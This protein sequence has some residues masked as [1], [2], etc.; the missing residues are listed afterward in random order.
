MGKVFS[1]VK[2]GLSMMVCGWMGCSMVREFKFISIKAD[3]KDRSNWVKDVE[4]VFLKIKTVKNGKDNGI[5]IS[6]R[7]KVNEN[8]FL[9]F[10]ILNL[11]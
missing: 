1:P 6:C 2:M 4:K 9:I 3:M 5:M 11:I 7:K 8:I 10:T